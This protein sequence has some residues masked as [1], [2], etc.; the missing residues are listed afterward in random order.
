MESSTPQ[1]DAFGLGKHDCTFGTTRETA[2]LRVPT[3]VEVGIGRITSKMPSPVKRMSV[4]EAFTDSERFR[5]RVQRPT[6]LV[7]EWR[8]PQNRGSSLGHFRH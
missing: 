7:P 6:E 8:H 1:R 4:P 5:E 2:L 3:F